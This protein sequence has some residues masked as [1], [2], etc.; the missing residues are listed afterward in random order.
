MNTVLN[1]DFSVLVVTSVLRRME[2]AII[3]SVI[4]ANMTSAGCVWE[5]GSPMV[6][7]IM[8]VLDTKRIQTLPTSR[9]MLK[10][11]KLSRS[12]STTMNVYVGF[13]SVCIGRC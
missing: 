9:C 5:T 11:E 13:P 8:S 12:T 7:S 10:H 6:Q 1:L 4:T 2:A 3:C